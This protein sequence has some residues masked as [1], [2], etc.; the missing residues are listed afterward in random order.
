MRSRF[1]EG[2]KRAPKLTAREAPRNYRSRC[3]AGFADTP[4]FNGTVLKETFG[5][6]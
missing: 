1:R 3:T 4:S 2:R 6:T 5:F